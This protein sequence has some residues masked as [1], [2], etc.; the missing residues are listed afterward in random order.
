MEG[1]GGKGRRE[2]KRSEGNRETLRTWGLAGTKSSSSCCK[3][4][5]SAP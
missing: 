2:K 5:R 3:D 4:M 1:K